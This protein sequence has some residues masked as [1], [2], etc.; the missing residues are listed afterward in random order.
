VLATSV[1]VALISASAQAAQDTPPAA[2]QSVVSQASL[3]RIRKALAEEHTLVITAALTPTFYA[4]ADAKVPTFDDYLKGWVPPRG[5]GGGVDLLQLVRAGI[6]KLQ[7][8]QRE[9]QAREIRAR[10]D[11]EL[12]ALAGA[13]VPP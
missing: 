7:Q 9:R 4:Q 8:A 6:H 1:S 10:I 5:P 12:A 3:D 13:D 2:S 11:R